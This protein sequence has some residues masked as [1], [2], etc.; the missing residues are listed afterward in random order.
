[1]PSKM[2]LFSVTHSHTQ[3]RTH[4]HTNV[5]VLCAVFLFRRRTCVF[6]N[7]SIID[8]YD[9]V[10]PVSFPSFSTSLFRIIVG[11][12]GL[13]VIYMHT[14]HTLHFTCNFT[15]EKT[16]NDS[17]NFYRKLLQ[18]RLRH[19][20]FCRIISGSGCMRYACTKNS[21]FSTR[22]TDFW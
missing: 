16:L 15:K 6:I 22:R 10:A 18:L 3:I 1:M 12:C 4:G 7:I 14:Q 20:N 13:L 5:C 11:F 2:Y 8:A 19:N 21:T 17:H 9:V